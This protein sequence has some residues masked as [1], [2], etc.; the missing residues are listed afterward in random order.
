MFKA[1]CSLGK[2]IKDKRPRLFKKLD[3]LV[4]VHKG[5]TREAK[6]DFIGQFPN[7]ASK[8]R[9]MNPDTTLRRSTFSMLW[10]SIIVTHDS[11]PSCKACG[12]MGYNMFG[13]GHRFKEY[14][15]HLCLNTSDHAWKKRRAT[16]KARYGTTNV[17]A[18]ESFKEKLP[19]ILAAKYG[20]G[21]INPS[22]ATEV[23]LKKVATYR[24]RYGEDHW[25]AAAESKV[26][27]KIALIEKL[28]VDNAMKLPSTLRKFRRNSRF[29]F[30]V[31]WPT[32]SEEVKSKMRA[33]SLARWGTANPASSTEMKVRFIAT[34]KE[35]NDDPIRVANR[36]TATI[37]T[38]R[39]NYGE[40]HPSKN[41][42]WLNKN[43]SVKNYQ[44]QYKGKRYRYQGWEDITIKRLVDLG[45]NVYTRNLETVRYTNGDKSNS[46]YHPDAC[47]VHPE[48]GK[49]FYVETKST[50]TLFGTGY[51]ASL[52]KNISK[53][54]A[55]IKQY[56]KSD[57]EFW[58]AI[59][60][61]RNEP[62]CWVR[63]PTKTRIIKA[64]L[65]IGYE[66]ARLQALG[67]SP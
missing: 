23:K 42:V 50:W 63:N 6:I 51:G 64:I 35:I 7:L 54:E 1:F 17:F 41:A 61:K 3:V 56:K 44:F 52:V 59:I 30:G 39:K 22:Q 34:Q 16:T 48:T 36:R 53:F 57:S 66:P 26:I 24:E 10:V 28:G 12:Y 65:S 19:S 4:N 33:T 8:L 2:D 18:S 5:K 9:T 32:Q 40:D 45:Y 14:C 27:Y 43:S 62:I 31:S 13:A 20:E 15:S 47:A 67:L 25:M 37:K 55:A 46:V 58:L 29:K 60:L 11:L 21:V 49:R 38:F